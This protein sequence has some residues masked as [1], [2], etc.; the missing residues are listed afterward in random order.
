VRGMMDGTDQAPVFRMG[1]GG[2]SLREW[3]AR[4]RA[5]GRRVVLTNGCF[6]LLHSGHVR[7]LAQA[8]GLGGALVI[9]L[10]G[11]ES[12]RALK[13][14]GRPVNSE[15]DRAEVM[16]ALRAVDAVVIFPDQRVTAV[17]DLLEPDCYA[18]GGDYTLESLNPEERAALERCG[19]EIHLLALVPGKS[20]TD[21]L[22]KW[23]AVA[24]ASGP[25]RIGVLGSGS[26]SNLQAIFDA[27]D[28][29][30]LDGRVA[31]VISDRE[32]ARILERA[33]EHGVPAVFVDPG[34]YRTRLGEAAQK[35][36][37]DRLRAAGVEIVALAG[38]MR[39]VKSE[40][41]DAFPG[42]VVNIHPSLLPAF[43]G[44]EA[45]R[46]ALEAGVKETGCTV[47]LVDEGMDTGPVLSQAVVPVLPDD[48]ATALHTR[49]Q[50][51]EH[52]LYPEAIRQLALSLRGE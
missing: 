10:N 6:D 8:R 39:L 9:A 43:P 17:I 44:L 26:G 5:E 7:Y 21:T 11:D 40:I 38:F 29:G 47:H 46:Q 50:V 48:D 52:Q 36:I 2:A 16:A 49:I 30:R 27:I 19:A 45:W 32:D 24:G 14:Q 3:R 22:A 37:R 51:A 41:L 42:R 13:G 1:G 31:V 15:E 28:D 12:V 35:E 23:G 18:K 34:P 25:V 20:T 33:R 4:M